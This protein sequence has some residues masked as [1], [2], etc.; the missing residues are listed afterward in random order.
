MTFFN[1]LQLRDILVGQAGWTE[2]AAR[3]FIG[4][5]NP[6]LDSVATKDYLRQSEERL[7]AYVE[8]KAM[9]IQIFTATLVLGTFGGLVALIL[10]RT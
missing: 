6:T 8:N 3:S 7:R 1:P 9:Q 2:D 10:T 5:L 4:A